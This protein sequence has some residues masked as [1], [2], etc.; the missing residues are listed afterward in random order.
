MPIALLLVG[1][2]VARAQQPCTLVDNAF[3][4][5]DSCVHINKTAFDVVSFPAGLGASAPWAAETGPASTFKYSR[6]VLEQTGR[7]MYGVPFS[8]SAVLKIDVTTER[9][10]TF[11]DVG[12][13]P[14]KWDGGV[15]ASRTSG[16]IYC[17][18]YAATT[19]LRI[20][21]ATDSVMTFGSLGAGGS[22]YS[23]GA[24]GDNGAIYAIPYN[25]DRVLK[26]SPG[27]N[28][29]QLVGP[30]VGGPG[31]GWAGGVRAL[32]GAIYGIPFFATSVLKIDPAGG[33]SITTFGAFAAGIMKWHGGARAAN[34]MI[35]GVPYSQP[36]VLRIDPKTD[37]AITFGNVGA[38][39]A[40]IHMWAGAVRASNGAIYCIPSLATTILKIAPADTTAQKSVDELETIG[41]V[42]AGLQKWVPADTLPSG[43]IFALPSSVPG[44]L[45]IGINSCVCEAGHAMD[46]Q[47]AGGELCTPGRYGSPAQ[48]A[49]T[50][51]DGHRR[52]WQDGECQQCPESMGPTLAALIALVFA[53]V[54]AARALVN[55]TLTMTQIIITAVGTV[56]IHAL[57]VI[58]IA[59]ERIGWPSIVK[60][61]LVVLS[62][63]ALRIDLAS[64]QCVLD[65]GEATKAGF[66]L[67]G[68]P[69]LIFLCS[70]ALD[71]IMRVVCA[72]RGKTSKRL[73]AA[74]NAAEDG[75]AES[76]ADGGRRCPA[77]CGATARHVR[78]AAAVA[79]QA[80]E[81]A[82]KGTVVCL[83]WLFVSMAGACWGWMQCKNGHLVANEAKCWTVHDAN[84][85]IGEWG[86]LFVVGLAAAPLLHIVLPFAIVTAVSTGRVFGRSR[87]AVAPG[88]AAGTIN[89]H[90]T[91]G[92]IHAQYKPA[93]RTRWLLIDMLYKSVLVW[94]RFVGSFDR[95]AQGVV[96]LVLVL[97]YHYA[98][99]YYQPFKVEVINSREG[100]LFAAFATSTAVQVCLVVASITYLKGPEDRSDFEAGSTEV[101]VMA[102]L[103]AWLLVV[104]AALI[105]RASF[106]TRWAVTKFR[107]ES[108]KDHNIKGM[109]ARFAVSRAVKSLHQHRNRYLA[110]L[111]V[112]LLVAVAILSFKF[113]AESGSSYQYIAAIVLVIGAG[114]V[115]GCLPALFEYLNAV[116]SDQQRLEDGAVLAEM[117]KQPGLQVGDE[118]WVLRG[119]A[120]P[121]NE[122]AWNDHRRLWRRGKVREIVDVPGTGRADGGDDCDGG[123][124]GGGSGDGTRSSDNNVVL[125][126][127]DGSE[128]VVHSAGGMVQT[129]SSATLLQRGRKLLRRVPIRSISVALLADEL[130]WPEA[131]KLAEPCE[132]HEI[133]FFISHS[134]H[135]DP[136]EKYRKLMAFAAE[137]RRKNGRDPTCWL[138][139]VR[140]AARAHRS[141]R[142]HGQSICCIDQSRIME[143]LSCLPVFLTAC[144]AILLLG[145]ST[146]TGRLWCIWEL[147][148]HFVF[149]PHSPI[150]IIPLGN[151]AEFSLADE[152]RDFD[153]RNAH[154]FDPNEER[155]IRHAI[156]A[157]KGGV[158]AFNA[159]IRGLYDR[160][161]RRNPMHSSGRDERA[162]PR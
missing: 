14:L 50:H 77:F 113:A 27:T 5:G 149:R 29:A 69:S 42:P 45:K 126:L 1:A 71:L 33:D 128:A 38:G 98:L 92:C 80:V 132:P 2:G 32:N 157:G 16:A 120:G 141:L 153:A 52:F 53:G 144:R 110:G 130:A 57:Q 111:A 117:L 75:G 85:N 43:A 137:Y 58:V 19:V 20:D 94:S 148:V 115:V 87:R 76:D 93:W 54:G 18:P 63:L 22:K 109:M 8:A 78:A 151:E 26:I 15:L 124:G 68:L 147:Y 46:P 9:A 28:T 82:A 135:D 72:W 139:K 17:L 35:Y 90:D 118:H 48:R 7:Y 83:Y 3:C 146:Y 95:Q 122:F 51:S 60:K 74:G 61:V 150:S 104:V 59:S 105:S 155:R 24:E 152:V 25:S 134:W 4:T 145:G 37:T 55:H 81:E 159:I 66:V 121:A 84:G 73:A 34:G 11:G 99:C 65:V 21:P 101:I 112:P 30:K 91:L 108:H 10:T 41:T 103:S 160:V 23:G 138:D 106:A 123:G 142:V 100:A 161:A 154:C 13:A 86:R 88:A 156:D 131:K 107:G 97:G 96:M 56:L 67:F 129:P 143:G 64:P 127:D 140:C 125:A 39:Q 116:F 133:D 12:A 44:V 79:V 102:S 36:A 40:G 62:R 158:D 89:N 70:L 6:G 119:D 114:V 47:L 136:H 31:A 49:V 162:S